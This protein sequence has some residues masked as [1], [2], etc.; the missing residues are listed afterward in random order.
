MKHLMI[1]M[2]KVKKEFR[3]TLAL[4]EVSFTIEEGVIFGLL[5][6]SGSGKTTTINILTGQITADKGYS[7]IL[8]RNSNQLTD[9]ELKK[10]GL[11]TDSSG[12]YEKLTLYDNVIFFAKYYGIDNKTVD[13]LLKRVGLYDSR[14]KI[15]SQLS[16]GMRQRMLSVRALINEP[17]ILFL[18]EPTSGLDPNTT[19]TIHELILEL[20]SRGTTI[21]LTTHD[22][23]EATLLCDYIALLNSGV[24]IEQGSPEEII[25]KYNQE[26]KVKVKYKNGSETVFSLKKLE[27]VAK[28][29]EN[30]LTIHSCEPTL[31]DIFIELTGGKLNV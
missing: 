16:T 1:Q 2:D 10:I 23:R 17:K 4:N 24:L 7:K 18:D 14:K 21:F 12:Y 20:K 19:K 13:N 27:E 11:V 26:K 3:D 8:G 30:I 15:A 28:N 6:P 31:E 9:Q 5:G 22:M 25:Q 29:V